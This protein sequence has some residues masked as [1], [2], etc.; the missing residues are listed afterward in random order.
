VLNERVS[1]DNKLERAWKEQSLSGLR[2]YPNIYLQ[3]LKKIK[4]RRI[5]VSQ[6]RFEL[7]ILTF[8]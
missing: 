8:I 7:V 4:N 2:Y 1:M 5:L 3:G 6:L